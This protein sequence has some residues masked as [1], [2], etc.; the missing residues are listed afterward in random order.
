LPTVPAATPIAPNPN[1][2]VLPIALAALPKPLSAF[3]PFVNDL[4]N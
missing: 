2:A 4:T 1:A 3:C